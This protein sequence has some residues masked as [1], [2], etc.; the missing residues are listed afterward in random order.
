MEDECL[1]GAADEKRLT[2]RNRRLLYEWRQLHRC[3]V[4]RQDM[5]CQVQECN[6]A[7]LP[8]RYLI[9][10]NIRSVCGVE[11]VERLGEPGVVN[12]PLFASHFYLLL[13]IPEGYP[14]VDAPARFRFLTRDK[15]GN[16][17]PHPWHPNIRFFG[18]FAGR[19]CLNMPDTYTDLA[20]CVERI[21]SYLRYELYHA[22]QEPPYPE[23][24]KVAG[25]VRTQG[26]FYD[27]IFF[28]QEPVL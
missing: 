24:L 21:A 3:T 15:D 19:V 5:K 27:W 20:W 2:G 23:D 7:G 28:D 25:W 13:E 16:A 14:C 1:I 17:I 18:E 8:V 26:E 11:N 22:L 12:A 6:S 10:Y 9:V 4:E